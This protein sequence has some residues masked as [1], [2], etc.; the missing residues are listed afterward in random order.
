MSAWIGWLNCN[1]SV[2][3]ALHGSSLAEFH[4][5][6]VSV[7]IH[8]LYMLLVA[9]LIA[10]SKNCWSFALSELFFDLLLCLKNSVVN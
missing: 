6:A 3:D 9:Y 5:P 7:Y 1:F 2:M 10:H 4:P 8:V